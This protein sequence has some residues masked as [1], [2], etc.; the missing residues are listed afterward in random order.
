MTSSMCFRL[1]L[2]K[3]VEICMKAS[4]FGIWLAMSRSFWVAV[5]LSCTACLER[6][7]QKET[8]LAC[9]M[10]LG[11][12]RVKY[13]YDPYTYLALLWNSSLV[14]RKKKITDIN[15]NRCKAVTNPMSDYIIVYLESKQKQLKNVGWTIRTEK[16][17]REYSGRK[18]QIQNP[19]FKYISH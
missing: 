14:I 6:I 5:T 7:R 3:A 15:I 8:H 4:S 12:K 1:Q 16:I 13:T 18:A 11:E 10:L 9:I 19:T 17:I 2:E